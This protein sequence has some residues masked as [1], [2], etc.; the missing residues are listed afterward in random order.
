MA[1]PYPSKEE[2]R[3]IFQPLSQAGQAPSFFEHV[4]DDVDWTIKGHS[5]MSRRY[6]SKADFVASTLELLGTKVLTKPLTM[7]VANVVGGGDSDEAVVEMEAMDAQC[8]NGN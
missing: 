5:P 3:S 8:R 7:Q 1:S 4:A 6:D 2:I